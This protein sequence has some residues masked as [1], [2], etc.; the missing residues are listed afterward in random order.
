[1]AQIVHGTDC[2]WHRLFMAQSLHVQDALMRV[3][4]LSASAS[5]RS[6]AWSARGSPAASPRSQEGLARLRDLASPVRPRSVHGSRRPSPARREGSRGVNK[7]SLITDDIVQ[8]LEEHD[9]EQVTPFQAMQLLVS[10]P[11][12][13]ACKTRPMQV[14][15]LCTL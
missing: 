15:A 3:E 11:L 12:C 4:Q 9:D 13:D 14:A 6:L 2:S 8:R 10:R 1:M 7:R 5:G